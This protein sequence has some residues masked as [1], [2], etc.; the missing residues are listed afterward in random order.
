MDN[1]VVF[2]SVFTTAVDDLA[3]LLLFVLLGVF[4]LRICKPLKKL[5]LPAGLIGGVIALILGPQVLGII[6]VP[7]TWGGMATPMINVVLT[8]TIF[9]TI[10]NKAK[11][12]KY[13]SAVDLI[14]LTYFAQM[15]VGT[16]VGFILGKVWP[17]LPKSWGVMA[18]FTYWGGHGAATTAGTVFEEMGN[19][20]MLSLG[21]IMATLGLIVAMLAGMIW[22]N[23]GAR[24]KWNSLETAAASGKSAEDTAPILLSKENRKPLGLN[25]I[26]SDVVNGLAFQLALVLLCMFLG[27]I[28]FTSLAKVPVPAF[29]N[30]M[31]KIP[32]LLY[33]IV[34]AIIVWFVMR[35]TGTEEYADIATIKNIGGVALELCVCSATATLNL[36]L[37]ADF[38]APILIHMVCIIVLMSFICMVLLRRWLK[39]D[40]FELGLMA[41]GQ[42]HGSTPSGLALARC[43]DPDSKVYAWEAFGV[44]LGIFTPITST[45]AAILPP[46]AMQS[47]W[48]VIAIGAAVTLAC[49]LFGELFVRKQAAK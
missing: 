40:W 38:L 44:A 45:L 28:L 30:V 47:E 1:G 46:L 26:S 29:A 25:T 34:G 43:V 42:G 7:S 36:K 22:V 10:I 2:G 17:N 16:L 23:I 8:T 49:V 33:G 4:L 14:I 18:I 19:E 13:A 37:F 31:K 9:G 20:G 5:Y 32:A 15:F 48:I 21:I 12:K 41:F 35:K 6:K 3:V 24:K 39:K 27:K 11:L